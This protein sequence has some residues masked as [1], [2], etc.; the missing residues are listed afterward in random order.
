MTAFDIVILSIPIL[1][2]AVWFGVFIHRVGIKN[3]RQGLKERMD[4]SE[5]Y[6]EDGNHIYYDRKYIRYQQQLKKKAAASQK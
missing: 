6:D 3:L 5:W 4:Q 2:L 1:L